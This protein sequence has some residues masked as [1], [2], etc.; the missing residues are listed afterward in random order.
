MRVSVPIMLAQAAL[1]IGQAA[2]DVSEQ[3]SQH[4]DFAMWKAIDRPW[5]TI[6]TPIFT[7]LSPNV[8]MD[9]DG[10]VNP[11]KSGDQAS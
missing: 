1:A 6:L 11:G 4:R 2:G 5:R 3:L 10:G 7:S 8:V 9:V